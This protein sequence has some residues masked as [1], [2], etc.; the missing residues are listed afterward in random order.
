MST[1]RPGKEGDA[2]CSIILT[3]VVSVCLLYDQG[4]TQRVF[5]QER[6]KKEKV[7]PELSTISNADEIGNLLHFVQEIAKVSV[8]KVNLVH[9]VYVRVLGV[10]TNVCKRLYTMC[11]RN[12]GTSD[13]VVIVD[14]KI[15]WKKR[16]RF[17]RA[18]LGFR[19]K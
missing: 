5:P 17:F 3:R 6:K 7:F 10:R 11:I 9:V 2:K 18:R 8:T 13:R 4:Y 15:R 1:M 14:E 19:E 12:H 16:I